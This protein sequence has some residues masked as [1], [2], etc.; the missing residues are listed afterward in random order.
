VVLIT[1]L[2]GRADRIAGI[3]AGADDFLTK[4]VDRTEVKLRVRNTIAAHS[5]FLESRRAED[6]IRQ[7]HDELET[8]VQERT[9]E[10]AAAKEQVE[11]QLSRI[12]SLRAIDLAILGT[13]DLRLALKTVLEETA[14]RLQAEIGAV[15]LL[16]PQTLMLELSSV[17]GNRRRDTERVTVRLGDGIS[18]RAALER[19]TIMA[20]NLA[21]VAMES[22]APV[23]AAVSAESIRAGYATPLIV[24][25]KVIGALSVGFR[26]SFNADQDWL[27]FFEALA[28]QAA[29]AIDSAKTLEA[30]QR[31]NVDLALAYDTTIEGWSRALDLRDEETEGHS[32]RVTEMAI[33]LGRLAAMSD[34]ELVHVKRGALLHDMGKLGIPDA[35]LLKPGKLTEDEWAIMRKHPAYAYE[36]LSPT[37]YLRPSL[38]IPYCHHE[39][40]DGSGYPRGLSGE[41]IPLAA[42]LFAVADVC[43]A[44]RA[45]RPYRKGWPEEKIREHISALAGTH[46]DPRAVELFDQLM[47][48]NAHG[49]AV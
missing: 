34:A 27:D 22:A 21:D 6:A 39:K 7:L 11:Q 12:K 40:W 33:A 48:G 26:S 3:R 29:M 1:A 45:N 20:P 41:H 32:Q 38:D 47:R 4:P 2:D 36:L 31:S 5:L 9:A 30:L 35:I 10:L 28:G 43:D 46:F 18:G 37:A 13:T 19:R 17:I 49:H 44:L 15:F 25:G 42:R 23:R 16:N 8:R 24:K 14:S